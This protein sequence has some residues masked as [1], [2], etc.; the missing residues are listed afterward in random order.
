MAD[1]LFGDDGTL[2]DKLAT[3]G[4]L[5]R[6]RARRRTPRR[7]H[8]RRRPLRHRRRPLPA[9]PSAPGPP[10][11]SSR[12]ATPS[13][14]PGT[15]SAIPGIRSDSDMFTLGYSFR[16]WDGEKSIA[17]G[18]SI[19]QLHQGHRRRGRHRPATSA[20]ATGSCAA[21][22]SDRGRPLAVVT[23]RAHR[24]GRDGASS[25]PA[26]S[27]PAPATTATTTATRP[28]SPGMDRFAGTIVH[29]Q[30]WPE[31]LDYAGKRVVVIGSGATAVTLVP[32]LADDGR[33][34]DHAPALARPTSPRCRPRIRWPICS[35]ACSR[36]LRGPGHPLVQG[37]H[38]PR[39]LPVEPAPARRW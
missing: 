17:D 5:S 38:D 14:A 32:A 7:P 33:A 9:E 19:L 27:S 13:A 26:S 3:R 18:A 16:P 6:S 31:D 30:A 12:R 36:A 2:N 4:R 1:E 35:G 22:W 11:P 39:L 15:S 28:T 10:T 21:D 29:P 23:G 20:S 8:R 24:H 25:P 34:R 37:A